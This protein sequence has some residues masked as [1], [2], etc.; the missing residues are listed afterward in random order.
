M[1]NLKFYYFVNAHCSNGVVSIKPSKGYF[2]SEEEVL[3][4][5]KEFKQFGVPISIEVETI[6][7]SEPCGKSN[8]GGFYAD[9]NGNLYESFAQL[10]S[11]RPKEKYYVF[12]YD[13][14][15]IEK[16]PV[17]KSIKDTRLQ[18]EMFQIGWKAITNIKESIQRRLN[19]N[20]C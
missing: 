9:E 2:E 14:Q 19:A 16:T 12:A 13:G 7:S 10:S 20:I 6:R 8:Y 17:T 4:Y 5:A 11:S 15:I 1:K 18:F 3:A